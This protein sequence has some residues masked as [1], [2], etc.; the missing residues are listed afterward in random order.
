MGYEPT[1]IIKYDDLKR[2][3]KELKEEQYSENSDISRIAGYILSCFYLDDLRYYPEFLGT[4]IVVCEPEFSSFNALV[5]ER[6]D[7]ENVYYVKS[8]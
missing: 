4:R 2:V 3:E 1:L 6:L 8:Y 7:E 5:R